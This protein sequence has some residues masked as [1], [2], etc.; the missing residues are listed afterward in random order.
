MTRRRLSGKITG[1]PGPPTRTEEALAPTV[2]SPA[3]VIQAEIRRSG[4]LTARLRWVAAGAGILGGPGL[5]ALLLLRLGAGPAM[6][7]DLARPALAHDL[8]M[9]SAGLAA[10][11]LGVGLS[12]G[13]PVS[14]AMLR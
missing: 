8:L 10:V 9:L 12:V 5:L 3:G 14:L 4:G 2:A 11:G 7:Q 1:A 13:A 6:L